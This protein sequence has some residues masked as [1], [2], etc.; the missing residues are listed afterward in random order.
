[1]AEEKVEVEAE[2]EAPAGKKLTPAKDVRPL[3]E[4]LDRMLEGGGADAPVEAAAE[5]APVEE[6]AEAEAAV[7]AAEG[8]DVSALVEE[9]GIDEAK[10][11]ML[12][13]AAQQMERTRGMDAKELAA[14]LSEDF[15]LRMSLEKLAGIAEDEAPMEMPAEMPAPPEMPMPPEGGM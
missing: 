7:G 10:A 5:E 11:M 12:F 15:Q 14:L 3:F 6:A 2:A 9:L 1:M 8:V 4:E 13:D